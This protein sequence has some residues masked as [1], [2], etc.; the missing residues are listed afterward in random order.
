MEAVNA[1]CFASDMSE[2][3][4]LGGLKISGGLTHAGAGDG[5]TWESVGGGVPC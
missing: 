1:D 5:G 4:S 3:A 2:S